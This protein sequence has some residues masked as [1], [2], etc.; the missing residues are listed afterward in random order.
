MHERIRCGQEFSTSFQLIDSPWAVQAVLWRRFRFLRRFRGCRQRGRR[1]ARA[2]RG[3]GAQPL[4]PFFRFEAVQT[5]SGAQ[6]QKQNAC[7]PS[8]PAREFAP[9]TIPNKSCL[10][11]PGRPDPLPRRAYQAGDRRRRQNGYLR[12]VG[13]LPRNEHRWKIMSIG[14]RD[15]WPPPAVS[16]GYGEVAERYFS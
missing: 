14:V 4:S 9:V 2:E 3:F 5:F 10:L 7:C 1:G 16:L 15:W 13:C 12:A 6:W 8:P 11:P